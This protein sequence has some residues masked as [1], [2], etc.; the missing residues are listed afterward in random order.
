MSQEFKLADS[1][2]HRFIQIFQEAMMLGVDGADL[3]RQM[4]FV[5][6]D[7]EPNTAVLSP[8]Y[9]QMIQEHYTKLIK[10]AQELK[11]ARDSQ[12]LIL[13]PEKGGSG[14]RN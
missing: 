3:M 1:A 11:S 8:G 14:E 7:N 12:S 4:K 2:L 13:D 10:Q 6:D 5:M 9:V